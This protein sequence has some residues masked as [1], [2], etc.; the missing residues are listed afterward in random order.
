VTRQPS[1]K[2]LLDACGV[3]SFLLPSLFASPIIGV[4]VVDSKMRFRAV[5]RTLA[6][7]NGVSVARHV[8]KPL[9]YV[10]GDAAPKSEV[11]LDQ[12][13]QTGQPI[14][15]VHIAAE[16]PA[17]SEIG[18]WIASYMPVLSAESRVTHVIGMALE[19]TQKESVD[20]SLNSM[21]D[22]LRQLES[23]LKDQSTHWSIQ[24]KKLVYERPEATLSA[25]ELAESCIAEAERIS[26]IISRPSVN[27]I[28]ALGRRGHAIS[29]GQGLGPADLRRETARFHRFVETGT[30]SRQAPCGIQ[31][32]QRGGSG[33]IP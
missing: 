8:G 7:M 24:E 13:F 28:P 1:G 16:L 12:V 10:L 9:R 29:A 22:S 31:K 19:V 21:V 27:K 23:T 15:N 6:R 20:R 5:N 30:G 18:Y 3:A 2:K 33:V 32:Q 25:I 11:L 4:A 26:G 14:S 17:R